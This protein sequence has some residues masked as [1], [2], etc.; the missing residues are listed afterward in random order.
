MRKLLALF[1]LIIITLVSC[2]D[3][4]EVDEIADN[5]DFGSLYCSQ[6]NVAEEFE[7]V[8]VSVDLNGDIE[9]DLGRTFGVLRG[10]ISDESEIK[11]QAFQGV[12]SS[13]IELDVPCGIGDFHLGEGNFKN[14]HISFLT[15]I[16]Y[17]RVCDLSLRK[18]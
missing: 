11:F 12:S 13:G 5:Y 10:T 4:I 6:L 3:E 7:N 14:L 2:S 16:E 8:Q 17:D 15:P 9:I 18:R 1:F